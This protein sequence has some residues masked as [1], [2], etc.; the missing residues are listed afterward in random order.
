MKNIFL[1]YSLI[2]VGTIGINFL[3]P[4]QKGDKFVILLTIFILTLPIACYKFYKT[5]AES[6]LPLF[7]T[8]VALLFVAWSFFLLG[9]FGILRGL[10]DIGFIVTVATPSLL[11]VFLELAIIAFLKRKQKI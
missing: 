7:L 4:L 5:T 11:V 3:H 9:W 2:V 10:E 6:L 1:A 8:T